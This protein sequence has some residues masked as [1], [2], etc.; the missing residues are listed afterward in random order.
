[1]ARKRRKAPKILLHPIFQMALSDY[2]QG[3]DL[4]WQKFYGDREKPQDWCWDP[5]KLPPTAKT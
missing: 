4:L 2:F 3:N 1:M 5:T